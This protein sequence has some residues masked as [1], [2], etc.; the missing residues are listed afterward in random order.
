MERKTRYRVY[1]HRGR[2]GNMKTDEE[3][4]ETKVARRM[5]D[6]NET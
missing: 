4:E 6:G 5:G 1:P 2:S 3:K